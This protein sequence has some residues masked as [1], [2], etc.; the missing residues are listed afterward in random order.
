MARIAYIFPGQGAQ[1]VG[2]GKELAETFASAR[3]VFDEVDEAL[4]EKLSQLI[5][6]GP[7]DKLTLTA[8]TQ[9]ALMA[10]SLAA[11][12]ALEAEFNV[13]IADAAYVAG[14]S[15]GEYSALAAAG[16]L[17][18]TDAA[19][20]LRARGN[21]MQA[22]VP[23]GAGAM[24]ALIG[25]VDVETAEAIAAEGAKAG[26]VAVAN[27]NNVGNV[28][29]SG[30]GAG[31]DAAIRAAKEKGVRA[32]PLDVSAPFHSPLMKP[33]AEAMREALAAIAIKAPA[34][35]VVANVTASPVSDPDEI[36]KLLVE[37][38]TARVRWRESVEWLAGEGKVDRF[39]ETGAG[40][41]LS[42]MIKRIASG[43]NTTALNTPA[44]LEAY[45]ASLSE[46]A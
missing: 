46:G 41:Q 8:N 37:Q 2:M 34:V 19:K 7:S 14:H 6:A 20:L 12:R 3:A 45:A 33:A 28:V 17:S 4:G 11:A 13:K 22:A 40:K 39:V 32:I 27:D 43:A 18:V 16:A 29:I 5:W 38:V 42:G 9:P 15:L 1:A 30:T 23:V 31:I 10:V 36:R 44:D 26:T 21:A 35:P 24:A 25:K